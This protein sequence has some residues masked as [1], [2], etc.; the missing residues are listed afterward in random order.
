MDTFLDFWGTMMKNF[1]S[2]RFKSLEDALVTII[3]AL[4]PIA[5]FFSIMSDRRPYNY[6]NIAVYGLISIG[7]LFY[8]AKYKTFKF[9]IFVALIILFNLLILTSQII[10]LKILEYPRTILLLSVFSII[11]YQFLI[12]IENKNN[13]FKLILLGGIFFA[14][15]FTFSYRSEIIHFDFANRLG[16]K[17][18]DQNDLSKYLSLFSLI[19]LVLLF[20]TPGKKK[21]FYLGSLL[22]F[23]AMILLAGSIS[24]LLC[25]LISILI[26][27]V[28]KTKRQ[29]R[30]FAILLILTL[31]LLVFLLLQLQAFSYFK[32]RIDQIFNALVNSDG[33]KDGSAMERQNLLM[34]SFRM[35]FTKPL[36]GFGYDQVQYQTEGIAQ[37]SHNNFTELAASFGVLAMVL[38]QAILLIPL[39][40]MAR[41]KK[42]NTTLVMLTLYLFIF[43]MFLV[44]FRKKIEFIL[45]PLFFSIAYTNVH[46]FMEVGIASKKLFL[47]T[48]FVQEG[49]REEIIK[50]PLVLC[51][52]NK[53][54][55]EPYLIQ[56]KETMAKT[57]DVVNFELND[58]QSQNQS[59]A[60]LSLIDTTKS[61]WHRSLSFKVDDIKPDVIYISAECLSL[62]M[63]FDVSIKRKIVCYI[64]DDFDVNNLYLSKR[65]SYVCSSRD[66]YNRLSEINKK[67]K[68]N[69]HYVNHKFGTHKSVNNYLCSYVNLNCSRRDINTVLK[70]FKDLRSVN[71][72]FRFAI[73]CSAYIL[74]E[75]KDLLRHKKI[76][77]IDVYDEGCEMLDILY[78]SKCVVMTPLQKANDI[79]QTIYSELN[80]PIVFTFNQEE[81]LNNKTSYVYNIKDDSEVIREICDLSQGE[82]VKTSTKN[83]AKLLETIEIYEYMCLF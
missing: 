59:E 24:N 46:S 13:I 77:Y 49:E 40:H 25:L 73:L 62:R 3:L 69:I 20:E 5:T 35:F 17:F 29:N 54:S 36:F 61:F 64:K 33:K 32:N 42:I 79:L 81:V 41:Q 76:D 14:V 31:G 9:D 30:I 7:V 75:L 55:D 70:H 27:I 15:Y 67:G 10:N 2:N 8:V 50:K 48:S 38:Y 82:K 78:V 37:F 11:I 58:S 56:F 28:F 74:G 16:A 72:D 6:I 12:N 4:I 66:I 51:I 47:R 80:K 52:S 44:I 63:M 22:I 21:Y 83:N 39:I 71:S 53:N 45:F 65:V 19:S 23:F 60:Q 26:F 1:I 18:S 68:Y 34:Q 57:V 43:Q